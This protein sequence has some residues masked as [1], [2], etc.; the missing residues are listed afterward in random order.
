MCHQGGRGRG[1]G[2]GWGWGDWD[3]GGRERG[4]GEGGG[5]GRGGVGGGGEGGEGRWG[6]LSF[7]LVHQ[8]GGRGGEVR[9]RRGRRG[10]QGGEGG[11]EGTVEEG[12]RGGEGKGV[13]SSNFVQ[14]MTPPSPTPPPVDRMTETLK[15]LPSHHSSYVRGKYVALG[16]MWLL[17]S[18]RVLW[19]AEIAC[20][21]F[22]GHADN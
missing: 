3:K 13:L 17:A 7:N 22:V 10:G 21:A 1:M 11:G 12:R 8:G 20:A 14:Q 2:G 18:C 9:G 5:R 6:V 15:T 19:L 4:R 16:G